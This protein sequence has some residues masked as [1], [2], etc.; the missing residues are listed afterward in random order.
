MA[1]PE[2]IPNDRL[3]LS[4]VPADNADWLTI[5]H[6]AVTF[7][8]YNALPNPWELSGRVGAALKAGTSELDSVTL[9]E[10]RTCLFIEQRSCY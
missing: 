2:L 9:T 3:K 8:G 4:A 10:L 6:F 7:D 1:V 5:S